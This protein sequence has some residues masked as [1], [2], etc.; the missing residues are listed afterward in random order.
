MD[1]G[2]PVAGDDAGDVRWVP[3]GDVAEQVLVPGLAEL[4]HDHG[5]IPTIT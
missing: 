5:V 2:R 4:L 1:R 3:L